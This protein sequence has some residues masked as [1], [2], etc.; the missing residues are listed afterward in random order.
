MKLP[1]FKTFLLLSCLL[2]VGYAA[3]DADE[4]EDPCE[5]QT[6]ALAEDS[7][8]MEA[9]DEMKNA[10][11]GVILPPSQGGEVLLDGDVTD[12]IEMYTPNCVGENDNATLWCK[13]DY[14][15]YTSDLEGACTDAGGQFVTGD[16]RLVCQTRDFRSELHYLNAPLCLGA[17]CEDTGDLFE[18]AWEAIAEDDLSQVDG[19]SCLAFFDNVDRPFPD[20]AAGSVWSKSFSFGIVA[21]IGLMATGS[22]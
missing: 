13:F 6:K 15:D 17:D 5:T 22:V 19:L 10:T 1:L 9:M 4:E 20:S 21:A 14:T 2:A 18:A 12:E 8:V 16:A 3:D 11:E 7:S